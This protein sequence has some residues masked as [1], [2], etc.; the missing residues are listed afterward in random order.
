MTGSETVSTFGIGIRYAHSKEP[1]VVGAVIDLKKCLDL[2]CRDGHKVLRGAYDY[3]CEE[4]GCPKE[5]NSSFEEGIPLRRDLDCVVI[6]TACKIAGRLNKSFDSV[7]GTFFEG[8]E[9]YP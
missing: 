3:L 5:K 8:M 2:R 6:E 7:I 9:I 4:S 1:S